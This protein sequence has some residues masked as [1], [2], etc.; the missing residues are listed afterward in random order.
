MH[1]LAYLDISLSAIFCDI[2]ISIIFTDIDTIHD[3]W[4]SPIL[5]IFIR[6]QI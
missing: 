6:F 3:D 1:H 4:V 2:G 5:V